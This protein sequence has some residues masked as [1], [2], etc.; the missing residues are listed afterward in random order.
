MAA[1][2]I[3]STLYQEQ[4]KQDFANVNKSKCD[5]ELHKDLS[6]IATDS[7][8]QHRYN[9]YPGRASFSQA[10]L[11]RR[12]QKVHCGLLAIF[13][14]LYMSYLIGR[15]FLSS[16]RGTTPATTRV[17][18]DTIHRLG[19]K[20]HM[21]Q[22]DM[23]TLV[24]GKLPTHYTL[25]SGDKIPAVALGVWKAGPG[26]VGPA[27]KAAL[28]AGYRHIDGAWIYGNELEVGEAIKA[29]GVPREEIW[30]TSKLWNTFHA[31]KDVEPVL[32]QSLERLGTKYLD[33]Y[34]MHW[35]VAF[36]NNGKNNDV[37]FE[38]TE[39]PYT[40]WKKLE[41]MV[42]KGKVRNIGISNFNIRRIKNLTANPLKIMPA[43]NQVELSYWN[44]QPE[45]LKWSKENGLLLE[46]YSPLG[47]DGKVKESLQIPEVQAVAK[48]LGITPAQAYISWHVQRGTVVLPKS[49][50][51]SRIEENLKVV[52]LPDSAFELLENA[53]A[54]HEPVRSVDPSKSW[55]VDIWK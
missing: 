11:K 44:P 2:P 7:P 34:L 15:S 32:D 35:P 8:K 39:N 29:S 37:D 24:N 40:T 38:L 43:V 5:W 41:E 14:V 18:M 6:S 31:P 21:K 53:A 47:S 51:P 13:I 48:E 50:T 54:S 10:E 27:V 3:P 30:I 52:T 23:S 46:A 26:E 45:L 16:R 9:A 33:L 19:E 49:V 12:R 28:N 55:G 4:E 22:H 1:P 25:P 36:K 42:E 20:M 17:L